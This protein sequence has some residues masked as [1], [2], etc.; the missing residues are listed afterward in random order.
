M[1]RTLPSSEPPV[2]LAFSSRLFS[3]FGNEHH[4]LVYRC[5]NLNLDQSSGLMTWSISSMG[6]TCKLIP[7]CVKTFSYGSTRFK[8]NLV[9]GVWSCLSFL[10]IRDSRHTMLAHERRSEQG[11]DWL[12]LNHR[13]IK[14]GPFSLIRPS[15]RQV[16]NFLSSSSWSSAAIWDIESGGR[17]SLNLKIGY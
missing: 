8:H 2:S 17:G 10:W 9:A 4:P 12:R 7:S 13:N 3:F 6:E 5:L 1:T 14:A 15:E 16:R 11:L